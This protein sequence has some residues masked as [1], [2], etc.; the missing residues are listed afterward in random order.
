MVF[1]R[2]GAKGNFEVSDSKTEHP[3]IEELKAIAHP[4]RFLI[5]KILL[6][7]E[8]NVGQ[9]EKISSIGQPMLSQQLSILRKAGLGNGAA[10]SS[11]A[12]ARHCKF[13]SVTSSS[14]ALIRGGLAKLGRVIIP[15]CINHD[16]RAHWRRPMVMMRHG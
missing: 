8:L 14:I 13:R 9:I 16:P 4:L 12:I 15:T 11:G 5:M 2:D 6:K 7:G 10:N 1:S 3:P